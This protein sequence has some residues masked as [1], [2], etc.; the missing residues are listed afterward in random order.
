MNKNKQ[1]PVAS[2]KV[3]AQPPKLSWKDRLSQVDYE[4]LQ[5]VF[6]LFD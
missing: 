6:N 5:T 2:S 1:A 3:Q 4:E